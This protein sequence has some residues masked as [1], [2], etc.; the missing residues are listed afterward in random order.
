MICTNCSGR[1]DH[2]DV[3]VNDADIDNAIELLLECPHCE[4]KYYAFLNHS[5][6]NRMS[7]DAR[8]DLQFGKTK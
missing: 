7:D 6:W 8:V 2:T 1:I 5:E 3:K 4:E